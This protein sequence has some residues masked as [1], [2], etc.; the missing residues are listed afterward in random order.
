VQLFGPVKSFG[1]RPIG[2]V[3]L[4]A[5]AIV[6]VAASIIY[7]GLL[8]AIFVTLVFG[9]GLPIYTGWKRLR[10]LALAGLV[11]LLLGGAF[12]G[13][14]LA[15]ELR[16]PVP[17]ASSYVGGAFGVGGPVL[18]N[19][20]ATP[21]L[22][23]T[24]ANFSFQATL[25]PGHLP[26]TSGK[27]YAI[28]FFVTACPYDTSNVSGF[29]G[30]GATN[31]T[32]V[33]R[34]PNGTSANQTETFHQVLTAP[35][36][37]YF[38][39]YAVAKNFTGTPPPAPAANVSCGTRSPNTVANVTT[40]CILL[41]PNSP[42]VNTIQ[43]PVVGSFFAI[44]ELLIGS[45]YASTFFYL[46]LPFY[47]GL[48]GYV[49]FKNRQARRKAAL[50]PAAAPTAAEETAP[51]SAPP[52]PEQKC[53]KCGAIV[54]ANESNCWKCGASLAGKAAEPPLPSGPAGPAGPS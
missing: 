31:F 38:Q 27:I 4:L 32:Q 41:Q 11:I 35:S 52:G 39:I 2:R 14:L 15:Q 3:V 7:L 1:T 30:S 36:I 45:V 19:A 46:G 17:P 37:W 22:S 18:D 10:S 49:F 21:H 50:A 20:S 42:N 9:L 40:T 53:P 6:A 51:A 16:A 8:A 26:S 43:G 34:F 47:I 5:I 13:V 33:V 44:W 48:L 25:H 29:C 28:V 24:D 54:Y 23:D 12:A